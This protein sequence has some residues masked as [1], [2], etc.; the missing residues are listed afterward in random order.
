MSY[1]TNEDARFERIIS[2]SMAYIWAALGAGCLVGA[3]FFGAWWHLVTALICWVMFKAFYH[4][5]PSRKDVPTVAEIRALAAK[6][7]AEQ[8]PAVRKVQPE[9]A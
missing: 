4:P 7:A 5:K 6:A 1:N 8:R 3:I 9:N 2:N